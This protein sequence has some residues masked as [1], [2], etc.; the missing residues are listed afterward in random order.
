MNMQRLLI[1]GLATLAA[2]AAAFLARGFLGGGTATVSAT[3]AP[4]IATSE[5]LVASSAI[6]A[7]QALNPT[8][9]HWQKWPKP[10]VD[11]SFITHDASPSIER[12]VTGTVARAPLV[13]GEPL[14]GTKIVHTDSAGFMAATLSPGMRAMSIPITTESG[15]GGFILPN[16]RVD[17][18]MTEQ[19]SD[20][21]KRYGARIV[22]ANVRVLAV[23][24][25]I[26]QDKDQKVVLAKTATLELSPD[27]A[28]AVERAQATGAIS[29]ALRPLSESN[30]AVASLQHRPPATISSVPD[31][32][33]GSVT[34]IRYGISSGFNGK[35]D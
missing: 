26:K 15:A 11:S 7:G 1:L 29:L 19:V 20:N 14:S 27:Q 13:S 33:S 17:L 28:R 4:M 6:Q 34:I 18:I 5:V 16:D 2:G 25:T 30:P 24:Q 35:K 12:A 21:P 22:L 9:V 32:D 3:P 10:S 8:L 31:D 23:D